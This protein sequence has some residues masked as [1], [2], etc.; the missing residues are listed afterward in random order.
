MDGPQICL[1]MFIF[2]KTSLDGVPTSNFEYLFS[3]QLR[4]NAKN[5]MIISKNLFEKLINMFCQISQHVTF[6]IKNIFSLQMVL[7]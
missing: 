7:G 4:E 5:W 1:D 6:Y 2:G 3:H